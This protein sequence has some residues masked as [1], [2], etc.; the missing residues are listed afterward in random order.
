MNKGWFRRHRQ[1]HNETDRLEAAFLTI[2][3]FGETLTPNLRAL[4]LALTTSD[5]LLSM[6]ISANNVV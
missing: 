6:G 1:T 5:I 4:R 2:E 3:K